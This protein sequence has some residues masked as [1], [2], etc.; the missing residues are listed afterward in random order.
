VSTAKSD[1]SVEIEPLLD[2]FEIPRNWGPLCER[3]WQR[4]F[5][6]DSAAEFCGRRDARYSATF[7][8]LVPAPTRAQPPIRE[9]Q[10]LD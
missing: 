8:R 4:Q 5:S 6:D 1:S 7:A 3:E 10:T 2:G 9:K